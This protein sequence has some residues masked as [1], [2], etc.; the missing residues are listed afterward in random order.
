MTSFEF[1]GKYIGSE[2]IESIVESET[3]TPAGGKMIDVVFKGGTSR[4][5]PE[6][7]MPYIITDE[8]SDDTS[9]QEKRLTPIVRECIETVLEYDMDFG[10]IET[11][12]KQLFSNLNFHYDRAESFMWK[13][14][15]TDFVPGFDSRRGVS[16]LDAYKVLASIP[17]EKSDRKH[18]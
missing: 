11:F 3:Q 18:S 7:V 15:D 17:N 10:D 8:I 4:S 14:N 2:E 12:T 9:L 1:V 6:K 13:G 16:V 5:Y